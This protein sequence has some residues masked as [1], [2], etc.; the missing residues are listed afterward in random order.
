[1]FFF[2]NSEVGVINL[3]AIEEISGTETCLGVQLA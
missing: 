3:G 2:A 1:M